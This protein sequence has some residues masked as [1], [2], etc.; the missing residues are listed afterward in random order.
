MLTSAATILNTGDAALAMLKHVLTDAKS[1]VAPPASLIDSADGVK[2]IQTNLTGDERDKVLASYDNLI[3]KKAGENAPKVGPLDYLIREREYIAGVL[4]TAAL[5]SL[6]APFWFNALKS[7]S[8]L[9]PIV[10][11]KE[12]AEQTPPK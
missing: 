4:M 9:R 8:N 3:V 6:R 2:W 7:V 11:S 5:L 12:Q 1:E 10:A